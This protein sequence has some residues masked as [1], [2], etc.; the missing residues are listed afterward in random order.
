MNGEKLSASK[1]YLPSC[2]G[3]FFSNLAFCL[4]DI[5]IDKEYD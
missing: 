2:S 3:V 1:V 4:I 5:E